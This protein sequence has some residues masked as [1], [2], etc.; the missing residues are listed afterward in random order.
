MSV[1]SSFLN[2]R[3]RFMVA[4]LGVAVALFL[5]CC[6]PS[7]EARG[8]PAPNEQIGIASWYGY[9]HSGRRT[10]NGEIHDPRLSTAAHRH[11]PFGSMV[12]VT[13]LA[14]GSSVIVRINDRGP[15]PKGRLIDLSE[16]AANRLGFL[17]VGL[18]SVS[19]QL[20]KRKR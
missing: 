10:A 8:V 15:Y 6:C 14:N 3:W 2:F 9:Q 20:I 16:S 1:Q 19:V 11:L 12:K 7:A 5:S 18:A 4:D 13:N 17:T